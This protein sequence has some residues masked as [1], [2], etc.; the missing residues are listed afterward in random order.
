M[1]EII[2]IR[3]IETDEY[4]FMQSR[5]YA[6]ISGERVECCYRFRY[7]ADGT[8]LLSVHVSRGDFVDYDGEVQ[9][10]LE[11]AER[12]TAGDIE[13]A[14]MIAIGFASRPGSVHEAEAV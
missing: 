9:D 4:A 2:H 1:T 7:D 10:W 11:T 12:V 5:T 13:A 14:R 3:E 6:T 8:A